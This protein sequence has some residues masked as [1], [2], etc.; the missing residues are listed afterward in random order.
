M[1]KLPFIMTIALIASGTWAG[2]ELSFL[3]TTKAQDVDIDIAKIGSGW[4]AIYKDGDHWFLSKTKVSTAIDQHGLVEIRTK[5]RNVIGL[6]K[7]G[8]LIER[9]LQVASLKKDKIGNPKPFIFNGT[10]YGLV[11]LKVKFKYYSPELQ[12][13]FDN[14]RNDVYFSDG[15]RRTLI[16]GGAKTYQSCERPVV[17][18][19]GDIDG[20]EQPDVIV[21]FSDDSENNA[22]TCLFLSSLAKEGQLLSKAGCQFFSG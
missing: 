10:E 18:W 9:E 12:K 15:K 6:V 17:R 5:F 7:A 11:V 4:F 8:N 1:S 21:D 2:A 22:S 16:Y 14:I 19:A 20:D 13:T 3:T